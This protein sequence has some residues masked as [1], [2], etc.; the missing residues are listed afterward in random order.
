MLHYRTERGPGVPNGAAPLAW[1]MR[2]ILESTSNN[3]MNPLKSEQLDA[4][5]RRYRARFCNGTD[6]SLIKLT[7]Y[8]NRSFELL[9]RS[10]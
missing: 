8:P 6:S 10:D 2:R 7:H 5:I 1:W 4:R 9:K 3:A